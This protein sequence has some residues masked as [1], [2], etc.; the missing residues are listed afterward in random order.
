MARLLLVDGDPASLLGFQTI[1]R[2]AGYSVLTALRGEWALDLLE[3]HD[4]DLVLSDL[5]LPDMSGL[6]VL[7][8]LRARTKQVPFVIVTEYG[9]TRD[10]VT[11]MR[12]GASDFV[13]KPLG[14]NNLLMTVESALTGRPPDDAIDAI[15]E[16]RERVAEPP[17]AHAA[18]R[19]ARVLVSV[20]DAPKDPRTMAD[21]S[22]LVFVSPGALRNW[23]RTAGISPR[24]SLVFARL[25]RSVALA[26][27]GH[28]PEN[29]LDVV[30]RRTLNGLLKL[31]G[32]SLHA[33]FP[34]DIETYLQQQQVVRDADALQ[35]I[36]RAIVTRKPRKTPSIRG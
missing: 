34:R 2:T 35:E 32:L 31:A 17:E 33:E 11:A 24:R 26:Q 27:R 30:D 28:R 5:R 21:W 4:V 15:E 10:A 13:E 8:S 36:R 22:R 9:S 25:L 18:A 3:Q 7:Q 14:A 16:P 29:L 23:C 12:I 1:L 6:K 20:L 19:W